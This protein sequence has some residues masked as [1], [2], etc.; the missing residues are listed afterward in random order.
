MSYHHQVQPVNVKAEVINYI[1]FALG[2]A[3]QLAFRQKC[4]AAAVCMVEVDM[5]TVDGYQSLID[6]QGHNI[7]AS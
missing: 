3:V 5:E 7:L 6:A 1:L 4:A 2:N